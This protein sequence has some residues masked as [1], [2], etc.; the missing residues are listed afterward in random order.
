[1]TTHQRAVRLRLSG[2]LV[3]VSPLRVATRHDGPL[4]DVELARDGQGRLIIPGSSLA[5]ALRSQLVGSFV[6]SAARDRDDLV[7]VEL[8]GSGAESG[9]ASRVYVDDA[10]AVGEPVVEIRQGVSIDRITSAAAAGHLFS[11]EHL[12]PGTRFTFSIE[13]HVPGNEAAGA[14]RERAEALLTTVESRLTRGELAVGGV[15][16][17]GS[18]LLRLEAS[19]RHL[20]DLSSARGALAFLRDGWVS[21]RD[22]MHLKSSTRADAAHPPRATPGAP[23][24]G[25]L[26][27]V[28]P[29]MP[30]GPLMSSAYAI[31]MPFDRLPLTTR[32]GD[33]LHVVLPGTSVKGA[34][35]SHA[36][37]IER[38]LRG[39]SAEEVPTA[40]LEQL[41]D[42]KLSIVHTVFGS[43][44]LK[45]G[46]GNSGG[47][48]VHEVEST[49]AISVD[50][51]RAAVFDSWSQAT[52]KEDATALLHGALREFNA[53]LH[54]SGDDALWFD[55]AT[56][57]AIDRWT[58]GVAE[59]VL[60]TSLEPYARSTESWSPIVLD[61][62]VHLIAQRAA[63]AIRD[64]ASHEAARV[65]GHEAARA[66]VAL[67]LHLLRDMSDHRIPLGSSTS[68]GLGDVS[69]ELSSARLLYTPI[70]DKL[71]DGLDA[72]KAGATIESTVADALANVE[73]VTSLDEAWSA[74]LR[75]PEA[76]GA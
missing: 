29:W 14:L 45:G 64:A 11:R 5:G 31:G 55:L 56:R 67:L 27:I 65:A 49:R 22:A 74:R 73:L 17:S 30:T 21:D 34:L 66:A 3:A 75:R 35:R 39:V 43:A 8:W 47:I 60:Y 58:G 26:R 61:L 13:V 18:G 70:D 71:L 42:P 44:S 2:T 10:V 62:D 12:A 19:E 59:G 46:L 51:W 7:G 1:M 6:T 52:T 50:R 25:V 76:V 24:P 68:R 16:S 15:V 32:R 41:N 37:R 36:E 28:A 57:N 23:R 54:N 72:D 40:F 33:D 9:R 48:A 53:E 63:L 38:T 4:V 20:T 69:L